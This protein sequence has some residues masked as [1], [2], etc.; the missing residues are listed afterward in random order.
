MI[1]LVMS[2][3][4]SRVYVMHVPVYDGMMVKKELRPDL[5][6]YLSTSYKNLNDTPTYGIF[7]LIHSLILYAMFQMY[8][9]IKI[10]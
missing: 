1:S 7:R 8:F 9:R 2:V 5:K 3:S 6:Q 10:F 4:D